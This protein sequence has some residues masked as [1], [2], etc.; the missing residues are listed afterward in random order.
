MAGREDGD[1]HAGSD[2]SEGWSA[3]SVLTAAGSRGVS[4]GARARA[5]GWA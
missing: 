3:D 4:G 1:A 5:A 2:P